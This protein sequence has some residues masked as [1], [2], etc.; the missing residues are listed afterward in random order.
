MEILRFFEILW[1]SMRFFE[2][3]WHPPGIS[4]FQQHN[5][6]GNWQQNWHSL[7][8]YWTFL[9]KSWDSLRLFEILW[10]S[11]EPMGQDAT[12]ES[13]SCYLGQLIGDWNG[14]WGGG[15]G[16]SCQQTTQGEIQLTAMEIDWDS[17]EDSRI[18][19]MI[20]IWFEFLFPSSSSSFLLLL[21]HFILLSFHIF[22]EERNATDRS[23]F[24]R[25][26]ICARIAS[27]SIQKSM[28]I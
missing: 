4:P 2:I 8:F 9:W 20:V 24:F 22:D 14:F 23:K 26:P 16:C 12:W 15:G 25:S 28:K 18:R 13:F 6:S 17:A 27:I 7:Q 21:F 11:L 5:K 1:D 10:D 3:L 19:A